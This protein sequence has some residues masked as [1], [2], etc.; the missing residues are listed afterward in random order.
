MMNLKSLFRLSHNGLSFPRFVGG[1]PIRSTA[2]SPPVAAGMT[3]LLLLLSSLAL[4]D[5]AA[6]GDYVLTKTLVGGSGVNQVTS[7]D[8]SAAYALGEDVA[9]TE[10]Q[11]GEWDEIAGYFGGRFGNSSHFT[12]VSSKIGTNHIMQDGYQVGV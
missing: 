4:A 5:V 3:I 11:S 12:L 10:S 1:N 8:Y 7:A 9:G 2:G 6:G